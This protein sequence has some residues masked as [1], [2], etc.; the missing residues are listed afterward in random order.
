MKSREF[1][2][3]RAFKNLAPVK[4]MSVSA[5]ADTYRMLPSTSSEPGHFKTDRTPYLR[6]IMDAFTDDKVHRVVAMTSS[7]VGKSECLNNVIGRYVMLDPCTLMLIQPSQELAEKYSKTRIMPMI[8]DTKV[9]TPLFNPRNQTILEKFFIGGQLIMTGSNS[10]G[11]LASQPVRIVLCDEVDRFATD[12]PGEGDPVKLAAARTTTFW[13]Y[14]IG[15]FSTPTIKDVSRIEREFKT[16]TQEFWSYKCPNCGE[17]HSLNFRNFVTDKV[18][19]FRCPDCGMDFTET[20]I[21]SAPQ[22]YIAENPAAY[23]KGIRSF[24]VNAFSSPWLSWK[25]IFQEWEESKGTPALEKV[26]YNTR[27]A[28]TYEYIAQAEDESVYMKRRETYP[29]ELPSNVLLLTAAVDVQGNRL[30]FEVVGWDRHL[31]SYGI[32]RGIIPGS[33]NQP[34]TWQALDSVLDREY[35]FYNGKRLKIMRTFIDSGYATRKVY[36]YCA[37]N[38]LKGRYAIKGKGAPGL[39]LL[40]QYS[41]PRGYGITLTILGVN[42]GKQEIFSR[43]AIRDEHC[44]MHFP[45]DDNFFSRRGYDESYFK[46]LFSEKRI[47]KRTSGVAYFTFVPL[48]RDIRNESLDLAVYAYSAMTSIISTRDVE[49]FFDEIEVSLSDDAPPPKPVV[50][51]KKVASRSLN[52]F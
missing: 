23:D 24:W 3:N 30:E 38:E 26:V 19:K 42:D 27:F 22:K 5:W 41:Y 35:K 9:L 34:E 39:P 21:K 2:F 16:G 37:A 17:F 32:L 1:L 14:K 52:I 44:K 45:A 31:E 36:E 28:E 33:P 25:Q 13:N 48:H 20:Q 11:N 49:S 43:L 46:Q 8:L 29:A 7:Q 12:L 6:D 18:I 10:P 15:L 4:K 50:K 47:M 51:K 40:Y